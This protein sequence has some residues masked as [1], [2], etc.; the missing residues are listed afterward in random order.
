MHIPFD[1]SVPLREICAIEIKHS[2]YTKESLQKIFF[3][4]L[5]I[6]AKLEIPCSF[7]EEW[8]CKPWP[9]RFIEYYATIEN[10]QLYLVQLPCGC[11]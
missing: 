5:D 11:S 8:L 9:S 6:L 10:N 2:V 1:Q 3:T 7:V 4:V